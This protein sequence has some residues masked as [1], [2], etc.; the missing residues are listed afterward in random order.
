MLIKRVAP[1]VLCL[2]LLAGCGSSGAARSIPPSQ[3]IAT[4]KGAQETSAPPNSAQSEQQ[5]PEE[6]PAVKDGE[7]EK[8]YPETVSATA[9]VAAPTS[10]PASTDTCSFHGFYKTTLHH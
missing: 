9:P 6:T 10:S 1:I 8:D 5:V 3:I 4:Q 2:L 7:D